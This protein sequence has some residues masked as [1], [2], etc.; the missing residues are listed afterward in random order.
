MRFTK[1]GNVMKVVL[2]ILLTSVAVTG[3]AVNLKGNKTLIP[4]ADP[5]IETNRTTEAPQEI[6]NVIIQKIPTITNNVVRPV[7]QAQSIMSKEI[8]VVNKVNAIVPEKRYVLSTSKVSV[9]VQGTL[10]YIVKPK[11][12][13]FEVMRQT[14]VHWK[15]IIKLNQLKAPAYT[16]HPG[17][18][19][20]VK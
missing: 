19:L 2:S 6:Q 14:G 5:I 12:T 7:T 3:C 17:Q 15:K 9:P 20:R 18:Y 11:D 16:I 13:V 10:F 1:K 4:A 8:L